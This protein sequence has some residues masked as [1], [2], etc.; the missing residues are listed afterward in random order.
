MRNTKWIRAS[1][2]E[3]DIRREYG[4]DDEWI[5]MIGFNKQDMDMMEQRKEI[6]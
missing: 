1:L 4:G 3:R 2:D 5:K 6:K